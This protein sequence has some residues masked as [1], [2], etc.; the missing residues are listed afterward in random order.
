[1]PG[2]KSNAKQNVDLN[3]NEVANTTPIY[4]NIL[5]DF[6]KEKFNACCSFDCLHAGNS[7]GYACKVITPFAFHIAQYSSSIFTY[8]IYARFCSDNYFSRFPYFIRISRRIDAHQRERNSC[9]MFKDVPT[10][11]HQVPC[12]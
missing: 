6:I 1:M 12:L 8:F 3:D 5:Q 9:C 10:G 4:M 11:H 7:I 2:K